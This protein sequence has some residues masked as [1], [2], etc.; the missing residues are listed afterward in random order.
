MSKLEL[1]Q[2][3]CLNQIMII[4]SSALIV[5]E[6]TILVSSQGTQK[7]IVTAERHIP[8]CKNIINKPKPPPQLRDQQSHQWGPNGRSPARPTP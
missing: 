3:K 6:N 5:A 8:K 1:W 7:V 2:T 4:T